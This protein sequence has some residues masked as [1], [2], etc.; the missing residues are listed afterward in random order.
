VRD[1]P[2][3][4]GIEIPKTGQPGR[5]GALATKSLLFVGEG[6]G[7]YATPPG[8]GGPMLRAYD[9]RTGAIISEFELPANQ[10]GVPMTYLHEGRQ[11][12][13]VAVGARGRPGEFVALTLP[14]PSAV[15]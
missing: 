13:V 7:I 15:K 10:S 3:L 12:I 2:A 1:H 4:E 8:G 5:A 11:Y 14:R 6:S 9:K